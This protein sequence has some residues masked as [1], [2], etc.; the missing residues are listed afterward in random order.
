M[1]LL[2]LIKRGGNC[3][4]DMEKIFDRMLQIFCILRIIII[5]NGSDQTTEDDV[6]NAVLKK[7]RQSVVCRPRRAFQL[8][9]ATGLEREV[10][11]EIV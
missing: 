10:L 2:I 5:R 4:G 7:N 6:L 8:R 1:L 11:I 9:R 3:D